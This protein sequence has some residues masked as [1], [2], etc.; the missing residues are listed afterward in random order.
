[1]EA[2]PA[3]T[4]AE[5]GRFLDWRE[6]LRDRLE[7]GHPARGLRVGLHG[8]QGKQS[9]RRQRGNFDYQTAHMF[10][11]GN[12]PLKNRTCSAPAA[13]KQIKKFST[14]IVRALGTS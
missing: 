10:P 13:A 9:D 7:R 3:G 8:R 11:P 2:W 6:V 5:A 14:A 1:M 12:T 4:P